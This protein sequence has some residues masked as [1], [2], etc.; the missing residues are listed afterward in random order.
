MAIEV[1]NTLEQNMDCFIMEC[2]RLFHDRWLGSHLSLFFCIHFFRQC[3]SVAFQCA[4]VFD[5]E[6]KFVLASDV[7]FKPPITIRSHYLHVGD[8]KGAMGE[9]ASYHERD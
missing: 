4:L 9:I 3:V 6:R 7:C 2:A 5:I 1:H 8:I